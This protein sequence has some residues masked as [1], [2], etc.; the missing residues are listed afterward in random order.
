MMVF[1][2][3]YNE[4]VN[5][6]AALNPIV[7]SQTRNYTNGA[8]SLLSPY[9]SRGVVSTKFIYA[10]IR[11]KYSAKE[12]ETFLKELLWRE[13]FQRLL[14]NNKDVFSPLPLPSNSGQVLPNA[15]MQASTGIIA[16]DYT[17][18]KLYKTGYMHN[19]VRMYTAAVCNMAGYYYYAPAQWMYYHLLDGDV[20]SNYYSWQWVYGLRNGKKYIA[21]QENIN[22]FC[23]TSQKDTFLDYSY[24]ELE[25]VN[26]IK[27][28][29]ENS[30]VR[31]TTLLPKNVDLKI[32]SAPILLYN[33]YNLDPTWHSDKEVNRILLL[34]PSHFK[35]YPV[36]EKVMNFI[37]QLSGNIKNI[38]VYVGEY[39]DLKEKYNNTFITKEHP[40]FNYKDAVT[41]QREWLADD[42]TE[43]FGSYSKY[44]KTV[45]KLYHGY[46]A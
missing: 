2:Q 19:H 13:Y 36:S 30:K 40:L 29:S 9:I 42:V 6:I 22:R 26:S 21:N 46:F 7:Y 44:L 45:K 43:S 37:L 27:A 5:R 18:A 3:K 1:S 17:I 15:L 33:S 16:I 32:N 23:G 28:L 20:A 41:E 24:Q 38:Q 39:N 35:R 12:S 31:F 14:Q 4:I 8:V 10:V 34:E 11:N 25:K